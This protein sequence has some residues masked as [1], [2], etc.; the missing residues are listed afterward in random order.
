M[1]RFLIVSLG[2]T[3]ILASAVRLTAQTDSVTPPAKKHKAVINPWSGSLIIDNQTT[4]ISPKNGLDFVIHHRFTSVQNGLSDLF[5]FYSASNIR[6]GL[7]YSITNNLMLGFGSEKDNKSQEFLIKYKLLSQSR[8]GVI[9]VS[10]SAYA[11]AVISTRKEEFYGL[12][13]RFSDRMSYYTELI[14]SRKW[15]DRLSTQLSLGYAHINKVDS[16]R[17]VTEDSL[18]EVIAYYPKYYNDALAVSVA[19]RFKITGS[20]GVIGEYE[21]PFALGKGGRHGDSNM[22]HKL[23]PLPDAALGFEINTMTHVFQLFVSS[24][25]AIVPQFNMITN[26]YDFTEKSGIMPGFNIIVKF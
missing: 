11:S 20:F 16:Y 3:L 24:Y 18:T 12:N 2:L 8:D 1:K 10:V 26:S 5:G 21:H 15:Y 23:K 13:Y 7:N 17:V 6:M 25:R 22:P 14:I 19:A 4:E 9:P